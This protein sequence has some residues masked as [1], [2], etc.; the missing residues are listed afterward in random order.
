MKRTRRAQR[1]PASK[2]ARANPRPPAGL[3][4][5]PGEMRS[6][7]REF[8]DDP[9]RPWQRVSLQQTCRALYEEDPGLLLPPTLRPFKSTLPLEHPAFMWWLR[10][11]MIARIFYA[12]PMKRVVSLCARNV[13]H[14]FHFISKRWRNVTFN[15]AMEWSLASGEIVLLGASDDADAV[16]YDYRNC[17]KFNERGHITKQDRGPTLRKKP[18]NSSLYW[19]WNRLDPPPSSSDAEDSMEWPT[20]ASSDAG[21]SLCELLR[22]STLKSST[23]AAYDTREFSSMSD[24]ESSNEDSDDVPFY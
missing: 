7:I 15:L 24:I 22:S 12:P 16:V 6:L 17:R 23:E 18:F 14:R 4:D 10:D 9:R 20:S 11:L 21:W 13:E 19:Q 1:G 5:L 3:L 2:R 8:L